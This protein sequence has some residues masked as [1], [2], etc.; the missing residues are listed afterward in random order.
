M[1]VVPVIK[2]SDLERSL[3]F[4]TRILG[5][6]PKWPEYAEAELAN[7]VIDLA[8]GDAWIQLS[9][10]AGDGKFGS[11]NRVWVD[12][13]DAIYKALT[14]R[15]YDASQRIESPVH[16]APIDQTWG[17]REWAIAD[18]D[19]NGLLFCGPVL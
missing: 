10:H 5:F 17:L 2:V 14:E 18:P 9:R 7:G 8:Q 13:V 19:G 1:K 12:D 16:T 11:V 3:D 6:A 15:G 4:Y